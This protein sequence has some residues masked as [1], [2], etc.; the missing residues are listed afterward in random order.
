M[1]FKANLEVDGNT[2]RVLE[3]NYSLERDIDQ[4]GKPASDVRGGTVTCRIESSGDTSFVEWMVSSKTRKS[5]SI[6]FEKTDEDAELKKLDFEDAYMVE[7]EESFGSQGST[8]MIET[9]RMSAK[10]IVIGGAE[11]ENDWPS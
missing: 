9:F 7:Y 6:I 8:G 5:G 4:F 10:K 1:S 11:H 2:Y 3:C